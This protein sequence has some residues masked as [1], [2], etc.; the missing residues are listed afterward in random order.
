VTLCDKT[1][2]TASRLSAACYYLDEIC[3]KLRFPIDS[4]GGARRCENRR[5]CYGY[6]HGQRR[7]RGRAAAGHAQ[8][9]V[10]HVSSAGRLAYAMIAITASWNATARSPLMA[11]SGSTCQ[12]KRVR[13]TRAHMYWPTHATPNSLAP[14]ARS[15]AWRHHRSRTHLQTRNRPA[16]DTCQAGFMQELAPSLHRP[17]VISA[18][19]P[20]E[21]TRSPR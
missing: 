11:G 2:A 9:A 16:T 5:L 15:R 13:E 14:A 6:R 8:S 1:H 7:G 17:T 19:D 12:T 18:N 20:A 21:L 10:V 3:K 4:R